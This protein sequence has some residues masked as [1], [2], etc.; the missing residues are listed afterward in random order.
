MTKPLHTNS[1]NMRILVSFWI[2]LGVT[3]VLFWPIF[4]YVDDVF[5]FYPAFYVYLALWVFGLSVWWI[6][7]GNQFAKLMLI[8]VALCAIAFPI[9]TIAT[10]DSAR[11]RYNAA[12]GDHR[13]ALKSMLYPGGMKKAQLNE[14][15]EP[16]SSWDDVELVDYLLTHGADPNVTSESGQTPLREAVQFNRAEMTKLLLRAGA[17]PDTCD[18]N[19]MTALMLAPQSGSFELAKELIAAGSN[20]DLRDVNGKSALDHARINGKDELV[21]LLWTAHGPPHW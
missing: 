4:F 9:W 5:V 1:R 12:R 2:G 18:Q 13:L 6:F 8:V 3:K 11:L 10:Y 14:A 15:L 19:G 7:K 21:R 17:K 20:L 16:V